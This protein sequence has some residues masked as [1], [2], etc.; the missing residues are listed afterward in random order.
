MYDGHLIYSHFATK[1]YI[2]EIVNTTLPDY[3]LHHNCQ[4]YDK[5]HQHGDKTY[6]RN[7]PDPNRPFYNSRWF[8]SP[9]RYLFLIRIGG[10]WNSTIANQFHLR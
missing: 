2:F 7:T 4:T 3:C 10:T 1:Y 9:N 8:R 5:F 6:C